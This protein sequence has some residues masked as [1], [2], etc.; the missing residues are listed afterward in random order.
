[1]KPN[2]PSDSIELD[3]GFRR[4][5]NQIQKDK[6]EKGQPPL[7]N[8]NDCVTSDSAMP[9]PTIVV[10][11]EGLHLQTNETRSSRESES[12]ELT[13]SDSVVTKENVIYDATD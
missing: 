7:V 10:M 1:M 4:L 2:S 6:I 13:G 5:L 8:N 12:I 11:D 3:A 9:P